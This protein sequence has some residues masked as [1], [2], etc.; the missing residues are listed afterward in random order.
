MAPSRYKL[1]LIDSLHKGMRKQNIVAVDLFCGIGGLTHGL[2]KEGLDVV[3]GIDFDPTCKF[4]Y[5]KNNKAKFINKSITEVSSNSIRK[6][7]PKGAIKVLVGCAPCQP[8]SS[9]NRKNIRAKQ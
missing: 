9:Y 3:A 7:Y 1:K 4:A 8:F 6:L 2:M 5:E